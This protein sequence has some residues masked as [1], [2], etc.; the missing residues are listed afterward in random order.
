MLPV[1][2]GAAVIPRLQADQPDPLLRVLRLVLRRA[3]A[4]VEANTP[5]VMAARTVELVD[6]HTKVDRTR[7]HLLEISTARTNKPSC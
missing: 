5:R 1:S 3:Q 6:Q 7:I 2:P 4:T